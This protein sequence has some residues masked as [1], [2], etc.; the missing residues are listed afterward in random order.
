MILIT[1][2]YKNVSQLIQDDKIMWKVADKNGDGVL[3]GE[4]WI[5]FSHP[6]EHP[7]M[8]PHI[9]EQTLRD[10]DT[11]QDGGLSFQE[12]IGDRAQDRDKEWLH[13]EKDKFDHDLDKDGDGK[14]TGSEILSWVVP[15][16]E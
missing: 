3:E 6:E 15:S 5:I 10:K 16:N 13:S 4:E 9:L 1:F 12:Y 11:D 7:A 14:L 2:I 8:L